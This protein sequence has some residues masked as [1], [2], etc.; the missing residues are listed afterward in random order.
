MSFCVEIFDHKKPENGLITVELEDVKTEKDTRLDTISYICESV[1][2]NSDS[3][4]KY[5]TSILETL[6]N[7]ITLLSSSDFCAVFCED[8]KIVSTSS[9]LKCLSLCELKPGT[10][11]AG[12][13]YMATHLKDSDNIFGYVM[14]KRVAVIST[15]IIED[16]RSKIKKHSDFP[17]NHPIVTPFL[18][19]P[20]LSNSTK[21]TQNC[22]GLLVMGCVSTTTEYTAEKIKNLM[23][24]IKLI[25]AITKKI[26]RCKNKLGDEVTR[27]SSTDDLKDQFLATMSHEIRT[28]LNGIMGMVTMLAD[29][30]PLNPKQTTYVKTLT[31]CV[32]QLSNLM[33]NILDFSKMSSNRFY[34]LKQPFSLFDAISDAFKMIE[35]G[36]LVKGLMLKKELPE[37]NSIPR[38]VG[39]SQRLTQILSNLL[40]NAV[41]FTEKGFVLLRTTF[42]EIMLS[43]TENNYVKKINVSFEVCD[44]GVGVPI[45]EQSKIFE[46]FHQSPS[47]ST[48]MSNSGTGLGLS[49]SRELVRLMGGRISVRSEGINGK[50]CV[51]SFSVVLDAEINEFSL[52]SDT[53][54]LLKKSKVLAVDDRPEIRLQLTEMLIKWGCTPF[55]VSGAEEGLK[56]VKCGMEFDA[57]IVDMCMPYMSGTEMAQELRRDVPNV[58][59]I[60]ISSIEINSGEK[61]FDIF[62]YKPISQNTL[63]PALLK[64]LNKKNNN[65]LKKSQSIKRIESKC[66]T[67]RELKNSAKR[68]ESHKKMEIAP[69]DEKEYQEEHHR[70]KKLYREKTSHERKSQERISLS[71]KYPKD[72]KIL[73]A[74]DEKNN[75]FTMIE[76]LNNM[77]F[78]TCERVENG[79]DCIEKV[80]TEKWDVVLMDIR[81]PIMDGI[82]ATRHIRAAKN[83]PYIIAISAGVLNSDKERCQMAGIDAYLPKP[84]TKE[85][86]K[87][88][89]APLIKNH[90]VRAQ[91]ATNS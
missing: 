52:S 8:D 87:I 89:L 30:G 25:N 34:L 7:E 86:L 37:H 74:E 88:A 57:I 70:E 60:G 13:N 80:K 84:I 58:P 42:K 33:N 46:V 75:A 12:S 68:K 40:G 85:S 22:V 4:L 32:F 90:K 51:F 45:E 48:Y 67:P 39:D 82:E 23:P 28:P 5:Y 54:K 55:V 11:C 76:M 47:L 15:N 71:R 63:F 17:S 3:Q 36:A 19:I 43:D 24:V 41:K 49:I 9:Q 14:K 1:L 29:A 62:L 66:T 38:L 56:Y 6:I 91:A 53:S 69:L 2:E 59:L 44:T 35:G 81:M 77:G 64:C 79:K 65:D 50:G 78:I 20:L 31:E 72:L 18:G 27:I 10:F 26:F 21:Q 73:V 83:P 61:Y 16:P